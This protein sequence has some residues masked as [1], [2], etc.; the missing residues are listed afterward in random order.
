MEVIPVIHICMVF[1]YDR[2]CDLLEMLNLINIRSTVATRR[3]LVDPIQRTNMR[4]L[5]AESRA[6]NLHTEG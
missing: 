2:L 3:K 6:F 4:G 1:G 5:M